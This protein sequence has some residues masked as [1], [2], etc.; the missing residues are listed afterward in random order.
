LRY[1]RT[2]L[3]E[4][5]YN[6]FVYVE[7]SLVK[8]LGIAIHEL[9]GSDA[10]KVSTLQTLVNQDYKTARRITVKRKFEW[11]EYESLMRLGRQLEIF[12]EI[13]RDCNAP[14]NP[15]VV[16]TPVLDE[17]PR[18]LAVT[19]FGAL[20]LEDLRG[21]P[22]EEPGM[23]VDYLRGYEKDGSFDMPRLMND[24]YFLAIKLL[25]NARHYVSAAKLL[26]SF[27]DTVAFIDARDVRDGFSLW[28]DTYADIASLGITA[29]ELWEFRN[30]LL[31]MT[32]LRSRAVA[33]G[34]TAPLIFYVGSMTR[35][36]PASSS[37]AKY[38][39]LKGLLD[40]IAAAISRWIET[41]NKTPD[42]WVDFVSRY[43]LTISDSRVSYL[44]VDQAPAQAPD[45]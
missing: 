41:Y 18:I 22:L 45:L 23:M 3:K 31:H 37:G 44:S 43:D 4:T 7:K 19:G 24:D 34:S 35:P 36:F 15:L 33:S 40:A 14:I 25:F 32:N 13:F 12:E 29:K 21:T 2:A 9:D 16:V 30:G 38:F 39:S 20:N 42:K 6:L 27:I 8:T 28:L 17:V 5:A 1:E 10:E 26:M 11:R